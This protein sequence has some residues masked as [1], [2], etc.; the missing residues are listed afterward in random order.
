MKR[1]LKVEGSSSRVC[2]IY[3]M[4][5]LKGSMC[6]E[7][8]VIPVVS[9]KKVLDVKQIETCFNE[10]EIIFGFVYKQLKLV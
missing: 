8:S 6:N 3:Y 2:Y 1:W 9:N 5:N 4:V 7:N 10:M